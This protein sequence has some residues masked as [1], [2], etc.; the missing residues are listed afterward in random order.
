MG[1]T[2][3]GFA[4][5]TEIQAALAQITLEFSIPDSVKL[6]LAMW[7]DGYHI[8]ISLEGHPGIS[9]CIPADDLSINYT[10]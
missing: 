1:D 7:A 2:Q 9:P 4:F 6:F 8:V 3:A 5:R 10:D